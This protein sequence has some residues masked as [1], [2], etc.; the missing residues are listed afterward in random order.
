MEQSKSIKEILDTYGKYT[1]LTMGTSMKPLIHEQRD[2]I[3][4]VKNKG[5]LKKY[6]VPV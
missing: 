4:V 5:R 2:N 6:D 3:I 1:G